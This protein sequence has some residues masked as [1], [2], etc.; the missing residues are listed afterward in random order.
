[1]LH[2]H[3]RQCIARS[4]LATKGKGRGGAT[5]TAN[6]HQPPPIRTSKDTPKLSKYLFTI[7][8]YSDLFT[9]TNPNQNYHSLMLQARVKSYPHPP[10][11]PIRLD[12]P[13][14][15]CVRKEVIIGEEGNPRLHRGRGL[16]EGGRRKGEERGGRGSHEPSRSTLGT[17]K[18]ERESRLSVSI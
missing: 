14:S 13:I 12:S 16:G 5:A 2:A 9:L 7:L 6:D 17:L 4:P 11:S 8:L 1:M 15:D 3:R 10:S 18:L